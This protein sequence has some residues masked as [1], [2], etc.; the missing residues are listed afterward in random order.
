[1]AATTELIHDSI[2]LTL[3]QAVE[4]ND[5]SVLILLFVILPASIT[6]FCIV[7]E[8]LLAFVLLSSPKARLLKAAI[9]SNVFGVITLF[10]GCV[11]MLALL[12]Y[13][14]SNQRMPLWVVAGYILPIGLAIWVKLSVFRS[15]IARQVRGRLPLLF[16]LSHVL[17]GVALYYAH[18]HYTTT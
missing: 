6:L 16:T 13:M 10:V 18:K 4:R 17:A 9:F 11:G 7:L 1:M 5:S 12:T 8:M 14:N 15:Y 3:A 2:P